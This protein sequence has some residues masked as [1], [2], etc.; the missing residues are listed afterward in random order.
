MSTVIHPTSFDIKEFDRFSAPQ[1]TNGIY[2]GHCVDNDQHFTHHYTVITDSAQKMLIGYRINHNM[3]TDQSFLETDVK[4][5]FITANDA[6][7]P[8]KITDVLFVTDYE[9]KMNN[10]KTAERIK[11]LGVFAAACFKISP[12]RVRQNLLRMFHMNDDTINTMMN[13]SKNDKPI[14]AALMRIHL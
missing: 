5:H 10:I 7:H 9:M 13:R 14:T 8:E 6:G 1:L 4:N 2:I 12:S 3:Q 11:K